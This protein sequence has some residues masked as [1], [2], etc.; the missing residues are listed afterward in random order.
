MRASISL[1]ALSVVGSLSA[2]LSSMMEQHKT[3][4][5]AMRDRE[6]AWKISASGRKEQL[7][8]LMDLETEVEEDESLEAALD[9]TNKEMEALAAVIAAARK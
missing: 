8:I 9:K 4:L 2:S 7:K 5:K 1:V 6:D 3:V